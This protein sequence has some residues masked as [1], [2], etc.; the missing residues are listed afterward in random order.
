M[1]TSWEL[2][3]DNY[4]VKNILLRRSERDPLLSSKLKDFLIYFIDYN[5][6]YAV[7]GCYL[8]SPLPVRWS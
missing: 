4:K 3:D 6:Q 1:N 2:L 8:I 5:D 7:F